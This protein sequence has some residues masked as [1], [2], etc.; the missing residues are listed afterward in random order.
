MSFS[1]FYKLSKHFW[2]L[3]HFSTLLTFKT[4]MTIPPSHSWIFPKKYSFKE[5][6]IDV[7]TLLHIASQALCGLLPT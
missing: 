4:H 7:I 1:L 2:T 6:N 3:V 5:A